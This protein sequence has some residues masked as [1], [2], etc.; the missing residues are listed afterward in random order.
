MS[1][2]LLVV[3]DDPS[4]RDYVATGFEELGWLVEKMADGADGLHMALESNY[5][6]IILDRNLPGMDGLTA[7][8]A[9]RG[10]KNQTPVIILSAISH[11][12]ERIKGL[13]AGGDDYVVKPFHF[14]ELHARADTILKRKAPDASKEVLEY[15]DLTMNL[16]ERRVARSGTV[17]NLLPREF[18][19]LEYFL[20]HSE[21]VVT[22][23][24]L[25]EGVWDY[26]NSPHMNVIDTHVSRLR[27]KLD[28][29]FAVP[30]LHTIRGVGYR[31]ATSP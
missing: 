13:R 10:A 14:S 25:L 8:K 12:D 19:L 23:A 26:S 22:R 31:L 5:D 11:V 28:E 15:A 27:K 18:K 6:L 30:L 16:S 7:L 20:R 4:T 21:R 29:D 24:M 9:I 2:R 17:L 1:R 3:E